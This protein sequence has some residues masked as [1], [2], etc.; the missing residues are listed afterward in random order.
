LKIFKTS[1]LA[2]F[3]LALMLSWSCDTRAQADEVI[4]AQPVPSYTCLR[5]LDKVALAVSVSKDVRRQ[6]KS[7]GAPD[8]GLEDQLFKMAS[9]RLSKTGISVVS[10]GDGS[11][12]GPLLRVVVDIDISDDEFT[13]TL[14]FSDLVSLVRAPDTQFATTLWTQMGHPAS[15]EAGPLKATLVDLLDR[16]MTD[17]VA[18]NPR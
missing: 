5:H 8:A 1:A 13:V 7:A 15:D 18:A 11:K 16:F 10:D 4:P 2:L 17:V 3:S 12:N 9:E 6:M 14:K